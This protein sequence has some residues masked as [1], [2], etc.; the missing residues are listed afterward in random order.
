MQTASAIAAT[1]PVPAGPL[2]VAPLPRL[3]TTGVVPETEALVLPPLRTTDEVERNRSTS[4][5][6]APRRAWWR[7]FGAAPLFMGVDVVALTVAAMLTPH[8][9]RFAAVV[10]LAV[11]AA[12]QA[13]ST[14]RTRLT[15]S[16]LDDAPRLLVV[17]LL[18]VSFTG[19]LGLGATEFTIAGQTRLLVLVFLTLLVSRTIS[20]RML[21]QLR[22][23]GVVAHR[24]IILGAGEVGVELARAMVEHP[25]HGLRPVGFI[26]AAP[27]MASDGLP[28]PVL[29][30]PE[31]LAEQIV[32]NGVDH[33]VIAFT[34]T[35]EIELV[36]AIRTCDRLHCEITV[37]PRLFELVPRTT[38]TDELQGM[39]LVR[40]HRAPFRALSWPLKRAMDVVLST[41]AILLL[42]P[43][44]LVISALVRIVDG[45]G[46]ILFR[47][48]RIGVDDK[49]FELFKFRS[50][51]PA[52]EHESNTTWNI[53]N[54]D[55][56]SW[57]GAIL[58]K[59][60][61]DELPQLFNILRGDMSIVGPRPERPH[62][63]AT[64]E[65]SLLRYGDRHRVPSGLTGWA[66][67]HGLRGDTSIEERARLDNYYIENWSLWLDLKIIL[68]TIPNIMHGSG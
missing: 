20:Y 21:E 23:R 2:R 35:R 64:F 34:A 60:S 50:L 31:T 10:A 5:L 17:A 56:M 65:S 13:M 8:T 28:A 29:G 4:T 19:M 38:H 25:Q 44:L 7:R 32:E 61:L 30:P 57:L 40:L 16:V 26:D 36:E 48:E 68:R 47:Q 39:P 49:A 51:R 62:F 55:R 45:P 46:R 27:R 15:M 1:M 6:E 66:Q 42:S 33:V 43:V 67:I 53:K 3:D 63:V 59:T 24:T 22:R 11:L 41:T 14:Y 18:A 54:D 52:D 58:R 12:G 37:V 9:W